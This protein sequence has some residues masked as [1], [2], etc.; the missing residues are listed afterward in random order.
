MNK[1]DYQKFYDQ[2]GALNGWDFSRLKCT[3]EGVEWDFYEEVIKRCKRSDILLDI[4]TGGGEAILSIADYALLLVGIDHSNGMMKTAN[5]NLMNSHKANVRF[6]HMDAD[7]LDFPARFFNIVSCRHSSFY[8]KEVERVLS[9]DGVFLTQQVSENDKLNIKQAFRRGQSFNE[10]DGTLKN[11]YVSELKKAG[12]TDVQSFDYDA[13]E[14]YQ[15]YEDLLFLLKYT[16]IIP[17]FGQSEND[18]VLLEKFIAKNQTERGIQTNSKR[19][20]IIAKK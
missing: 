12:F 3:S 5:E 17:N 4:G 9:K 2:V 6:L 20:M 18:F 1:L 19:F 13:T 8:P 11:N 16:P 10:K 14:Y 15:S 7:R